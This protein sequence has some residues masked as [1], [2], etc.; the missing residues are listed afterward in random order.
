[1][2]HSL[3]V[4]SRLC[5]AALCRCK[6][7]LQRCDAR[8]Q[9][10]KKACG[11]WEGNVPTMPHA[12]SCLSTKTM[13]FA[14]ATWALLC[15]VCLAILCS[16]GPCSMQVMRRAPSWAAIRPKILVPLPRES[17]WPPAA[18]GKQVN[19]VIQTCKK[20]TSFLLQTVSAVDCICRHTQKE[21]YF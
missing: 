10:S 4:D 18:T 19:A 8:M 12:C 1:M 15:S 11:H 2:N 5:I 20:V 21:L 14:P 6:R 16:M 13:C 17:T 9:G 7:T 3:T